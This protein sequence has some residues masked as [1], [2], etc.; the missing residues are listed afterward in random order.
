[1][2]KAHIH[3]AL[4]ALAAYAAVAFIQRSVFVVPV[5]GAYLPR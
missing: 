3:T 4:V 5:V 1:M 2:H